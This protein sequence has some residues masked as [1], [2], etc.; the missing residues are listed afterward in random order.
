MPEHR[1]RVSK[2]GTIGCKCGT[3]STK[4]DKEAWD[5]IRATVVSRDEWLAAA[6]I[7]TLF[8]LAIMSI[9]VWHIFA[10]VG[11]MFP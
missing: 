7:G 6:L 3:L 8:V 11:R 4:S 5:H 1:L 2:D 10:P 9:F